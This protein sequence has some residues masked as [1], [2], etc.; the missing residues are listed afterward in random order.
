MKKRTLIFKNEL[1]VREKTAENEDKIIE[2]YFLRFNEP[3]E[4]WSGFFEKVSPTAIR[5]LFNSPNDVKCLINHDHK[6][7][8]GSRDNSTLKLSVDEVGLFGSVL[9]NP[10]DTEAL[11]AYERVKRGDISGC[12]FGF[13]VNSGGE[14]YEYRDDGT[15]HVTLTDINVY[16]VSVVAFPAY[17]ST[18]VIARQKEFEKTKSIELEKVRSSVLNKYKEEKK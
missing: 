4:L 1:K 3:T 8:I 7:V 17:E 6:L 18:H 12:S 16:E 9:I 5:D 15:T 10:S 13:S 11:N 2:G 14:S